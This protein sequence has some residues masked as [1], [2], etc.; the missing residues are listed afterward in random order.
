MYTY[1]YVYICI[2]TYIYANMCIYIYIHKYFHIHKYVHVHI[3]RTQKYQIKRRH[4]AY[5][6]VC[7]YMYIHKTPIHLCVRVCIRVCIYIHTR[8]HIHTQN[9]RVLDLKALGIPD[10]LYVKV[11]GLF[12]SFFFEI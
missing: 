11:T 3:Y 8:T 1:V 12:F 4:W 5:P 9:T 7:V 2:Y 6:C 10:K